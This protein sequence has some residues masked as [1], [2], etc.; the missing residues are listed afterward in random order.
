HLGQKSLAPC[1]LLGRG[2]LVITESEL[3]AAHEPSPRLRLQ[4]YFRADGSGFPELPL[5]IDPAFEGR[6]GKLFELSLPGF[7]FH[8][9]AAQALRQ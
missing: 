4:G 5:W 8:Y 1:A 7:L 2:L 9:E 3:L 6:I